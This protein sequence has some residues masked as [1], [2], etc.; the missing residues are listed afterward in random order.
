MKSE[1]R[2]DMEEGGQLSVTN[3][4]ITLSELDLRH[5]INPRSRSQVVITA[6]DGA[7]ARQVVFQ[8]LR[9]ICSVLLQHRSSANDLH[10]ALQKL[11]DVLG[12][13]EPASG[14]LGCMDYVLFP[15]MMVVDSIVPARNHPPAGSRTDAS[16]QGGDA[17]EIEQTPIPAAKSDRV[18]EAALGKDRIEPFSMGRSMVLSCGLHVHRMPPSAA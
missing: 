12:H 16:V 3:C 17:A 9:P 5:E 1:H 7:A 8:T 15:L 10:E 11:Q 13:A 2:L 6:M 4:N 18:A 14:L